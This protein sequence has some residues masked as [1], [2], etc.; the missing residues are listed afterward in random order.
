MAGRCGEISP[1]VGLLV[2][3]PQLWFLQGG[4]AP[5]K[6]KVEQ[7]SADMDVSKK[8]DYFFTFLWYY[9]QIIPN[10]S[11]RGWFI[12]FLALQEECMV[13]DCLE[14]WVFSMI[15]NSFT[16]LYVAVSIYIYL[17]IYMHIYRDI[18]R[19]RY[20]YI[21][22]QTYIDTYRYKYRQIYIDIY[23]YV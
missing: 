12:F 16:Y 20:I 13:R 4:K 11:L 6:R 3:H 1:S 9:T 5:G 17:Y 15:S 7:S 8:W 23:I 10:I 21:A 19:H 14:T 2:I 22:I 18:Y